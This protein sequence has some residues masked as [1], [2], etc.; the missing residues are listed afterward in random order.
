MSD[1]VEFGNVQFSQPD[2]ALRPDQDPHFAV[3]AVGEPVD[4][5]LPIYVAYET[6]K[7]IEKHVSADTSIELG[8]VLL[9]SQHVD[10]HE[11]PFVVVRESL[12]AQHYEATKGSF[13]FTLDTW[14]D[15]LHRTGTYPPGTKV[16][17]WYHSHPGWGIFLSEMD[18]FICQGFF[19]NPLDVALVV[20]PCQ[21]HR[22]WFHW[23]QSDGT[24]RKRRNAGFYLFDSRHRLPLLQRTAVLLYEAEQPMNRSSMS[25]STMRTPNRVFSSPEL[26]EGLQPPAQVF[27]S[28]P[29]TTWPIIGMTVSIGLQTILIAV[30]AWSL[31][32][33][34]STAETSNETAYQNV[35]KGLIESIDQESTPPVS[36]QRLE[37]LLSRQQEIQE[38]KSQNQL[39]T[40]AAEASLKQVQDYSA[41]LSRSAKELQ[42]VNALN[43]DL[44]ARVEALESAQALA[45]SNAADKTGKT[46]EGNEAIT[47]SWWSPGVTSSIVGILGVVVGGVAGGWWIAR[48]HSLLDVAHEE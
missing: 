28:Q 21:D 5:Q 19:N 35:I 7:A 26:G 37:S 42:R 4:E 13:K 25:Q 45:A 41:E 31:M 20:D 43:R 39:L 36:R 48:R 30:V 10:D 24:N 32:S 18:L 15:L 22:G 8:G 14:Q 11:R 29:D 34:R 44:D 12:E 2:R 9:G 17:G 27:I 40:I 47:A 46:D 23:D 6:L 3:V 33:P 38:L 1:D 16:V